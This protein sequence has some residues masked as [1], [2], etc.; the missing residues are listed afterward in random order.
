MLTLQVMTFH[1]CSD[2]VLER[3]VIEKRLSLVKALEESDKSIYCFFSYFKC[4]F[5]TL[6]AFL[7][8]FQIVFINYLV[9][10]IIKSK[11]CWLIN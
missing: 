7:R 8:T 9:E 6:S 4:F 2:A 1:S 5:H 10:L 11:L 3:V